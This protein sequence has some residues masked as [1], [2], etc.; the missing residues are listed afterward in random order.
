MKVK[1]A[2]RDMN[3]EETW[4]LIGT[5]PAADST[6]HVGGNTRKKIF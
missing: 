3:D 2:A 1:L 5:P 4:T 6:P